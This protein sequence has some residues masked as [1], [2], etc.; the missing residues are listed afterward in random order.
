MLNAAQLWREL[1]NGSF[2]VVGFESLHLHMAEA[3]L[4]QK[5]SHF[6]ELKSKMAEEEGFEPS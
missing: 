6:W 5:S 3:R 1:L 4:K 2:C